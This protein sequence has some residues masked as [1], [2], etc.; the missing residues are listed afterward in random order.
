[1]LKKKV[2]VLKKAWIVG[3]DLKKHFCQIIKNFAVT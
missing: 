3:R 2:F 1:M